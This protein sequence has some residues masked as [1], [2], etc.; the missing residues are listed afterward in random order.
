MR[1]ITPQPGGRLAVLPFVLLAGAVPLAAQE[2]EGPRWSIAAVASTLGLGGELSGRANPIVGLRGGYYLFGWSTSNDVEGISYD[3][4]PKLR[5]GTALLDLYPGGSWFRVSGGIVYGSPEVNAT[6]VL[7]GPVTIGSTTYP[8]AAVGSL[9]GHVYYS[10][11]IRPYAGI[12]VAANTRFTVTF[13]IGVVFAGYPTVDL[14]ADSPLT[15]SALAQLEQNLA[16]EEAQVQAE[17]ETRKWAK[18]YPAVSL[19]FKYKL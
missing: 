18:F 7:D 12:G 19:G 2:D 3:L 10:R 1:L 4:K 9:K 15:G 8:P 17:I 6:G 5:N 16:A 13:D 14:T 11:G